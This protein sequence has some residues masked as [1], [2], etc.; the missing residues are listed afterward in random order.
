MLFTL[1]FLGLLAPTHPAA[2]VVW[3]FGAHAQKDGIVLV[4]LSA[5]LE[6]GWHMYATTLPSADGPL[7][8]VFRFAPSTSFSIVGELHE[9]DPVEEYD[10]NFAMMVRYHSGQP[11]FVLKIKPSGD[12]PFVVAGELEYMVCNE[13]T[14]LPPVTVP[15]RITVPAT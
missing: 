12:A 3:S 5:Q 2:P 4:E 14:C 1:S 15:F 8:T 13:K 6:D 10:P 9:P 11:R 7:P